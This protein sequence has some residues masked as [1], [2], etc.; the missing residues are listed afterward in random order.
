MQ[1]I[2]K[3]VDIGATGMLG[4]PVTQELIASGFQLTIVARDIPKAKT[5]FPA[6][7]IVE[8]DLHNKSSLIKAFTGQDAVYC[9]LNIPQSTKPHEWL[10]ER[11]GLD[12]L[13]EAAHQ[14]GIRCISLISSIV[15]NYQGMN[16]FQWWVFD[17]KHEAVR[18][19]KQS[20]I[21]YLIFYPST[22]MDSFLYTYRRGNNILLAGTSHAPMYYISGEDYGKQAA[23][24]F[25]NYSGESKEYIVQGLEAY[26]ADQAA[27]LFIAN[28]TKAKLRVLKTPLGLLK[29]L[30]N[31][32]QQIHYGAHIIEALNNYPEKF[33]AQTTWEELGKPTLSLKEF[34]AK[35]SK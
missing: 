27:K 30:G 7:S 3:I 8:G 15:M 9:N 26:T 24:A 25:K 28:Y 33:L 6:V 32:N 5:I 19:I 29:L 1:P 20:G 10:P 31:F 22:F 14:T 35:H 4:K 2:S 13:L 21:P 17:V 18:K 16:G 11:E 23:R 34:A 12:N